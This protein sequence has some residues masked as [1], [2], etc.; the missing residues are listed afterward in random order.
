MLCLSGSVF[1]LFPFHPQPPGGTADPTWG[2][3]E[4]KGSSETWA[5]VGNTTQ[6]PKA[7][8]PGRR[9]E[10]HLWASAVALSSCSETFHCIWARTARPSQTSSGNRSCHTLSSCSLSSPGQENRICIAHGSVYHFIYDMLAIE[11]CS[12]WNLQGQIYRTD[13]DAGCG[14]LD[15]DFSTM[16]IWGRR[17]L[18]YLAGGRA[19]LCIV[20]GATASH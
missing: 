4:L 16:G 3:R 7:L 19:V 17:I 10:C 20:E 2:A 8:L 13:M 18:C 1:H 9:G 5:R 6:K 14:E 12:Y 11:I 15:R